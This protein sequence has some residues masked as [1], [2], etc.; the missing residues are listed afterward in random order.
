MTQQQIDLIVENINAILNKAKEH[1]LAFEEIC[2]KDYLQGRVQ[3]P[4]TAIVYS[5]FDPESQNIPGFTIQKVL[6][7]GIKKMFLPELFN[8]EIMIEVFGDT[9]K[10]WTTDEVKAKLSLMG[11]KFKLL[12]FSINKDT[13]TLSKLQ[14]LSM[15][16]FDDKGNANVSDRVTLYKVS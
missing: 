13:Y 6:Y 11:E 16:G 14:L 3:Y 12:T 1:I 4:I 9:A 8:D 7:G 5:A 2:D 15:D 10:P